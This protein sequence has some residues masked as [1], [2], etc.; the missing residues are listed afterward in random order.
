MKY[1]SR[2]DQEAMLG[3]PVLAIVGGSILFL[4]LDSY[5]IGTIKAAIS[6]VIAATVIM[7][8]MLFDIKKLT[9]ENE[10][11]KYERVFGTKQ[12]NL[13]NV[14]EIWDFN[15]WG[16]YARRQLI[17]HFQD[18][19]KIRVKETRDKVFEELKQE[20]KKLDLNIEFKRVRK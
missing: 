13:A 9:I 2:F 19:R 3:F 16:L 7:W 1:S 14:K 10:E 5:Q 18:G 6:G 15:H 20:L 17:I 12:F 4:V 11:I 8:S